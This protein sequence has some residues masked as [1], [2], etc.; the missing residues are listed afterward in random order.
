[1]Q[2]KILLNACLCLC[3]AFSSFAQSLPTQPVEVDKWLKTWLLWGPF[4]LKQ[5]DDPSKLLQHLEG[6]D[7][8]VL[9][10]LGGE[11]NL[12][13]KP[14]NTVTVG[15]K[16]YKW[17]L[18][19]T[20]DSTIDLQKTI[21]QASPVFAYAYTEV[22]ADA[23]QMHFLSFGTN[24]GGTLWFNGIKVWDYTPDRGLKAD[25]D[26]VPVLLKKGVNKI[27]LKVEQRG[28]RWEFC[29]R[30]RAFSLD[31]LSKSDLFRINSNET[32]E[33][34]L[35]S[36]YST[37][38]LKALVEDV[39]V[40]IKNSD[41]KTIFTNRFTSGFAQPID[42]GTTDYRFYTAHFKV[43]LKTGESINTSQNFY[44]GKRTEHE[45]FSKG[46]TAYRIALTNDASESEKWAANEL[47]RWLKEASG[48]L[49]P[50]ENL[51]KPF[52]G[53]QIILGYSILARDR[54]G[55]PAPAD[56]D[57]GYHYMNAG[58]D[59]LIF[60][61]KKRGTMYGV[62]AF[63]ENELGCRWY[64]PGYSVIPKK[65]EFKFSRLEHHE[66]PGV[67]V[68]NDFY[69][70][71]FDPIWATRNKM[72]GSMATPVQP[73]G[74]ESY[75]S[76]HTF[77]PL[78]SPA[79]FYDKHPEYFSL[80]NGKR[81]HERAQL[82]LSNPDVLKIITE[83]IKKQMRD[84][85]EY[86]IYDVS[87]NDWYNPCQCDKCQ[88]I[89]KKEGAESGIVIWFVNQVADAIA[90]EFPQKFIGTL[91]YQYTRKPPLHIR[92]K[93]NVVVRFCSIEC[94]FAH[95]FK[96]CPENQ[97]FL[98]ELNDWASRAPHLY[99]WDYVV[100]FNHYVMPFPNFNVLQSNIK[101]FRDNNAIGIMEQA[102]YQ[103]RGGEFAELR[104]Y[105]ISK[106]LWNP[107][108]DVP[109]VLSDFMHGYYGRSGKF[110]RQYFDLLQNQ[111][112]SDTHIH[113][114]LEPTDKIFTDEFVRKAFTLFEEAK[115]V[116]DNDEILHHVEMA[117]L[118]ILYLKCKRTP[119]LAKYDGTYD[120]FSKIAAR[121]KITH[122]AESG[123]LEA[124][125]SWMK[126][127]R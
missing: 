12:Q 126:S 44:A 51:G 57:E 1:M 18:H 93:D 119:A 15:K 94:C 78:L 76:V 103:S 56:S 42:L 13:V 55:R 30:L 95:D 16:T 3:L 28:N 10:K 63:L 66:K 70:E 52:R 41:D 65:T 37:N 87:Q 68:R 36:S 90:T 110:V 2:R 89:V 81:I 111:V 4:Q 88:S 79:E 31:A 75:W 92:P 69:F 17:T 118:P 117:S 125:H 50:I 33:S 19:T 20:P 72:N 73:G 97:G 5:P 116:A 127:V 77:Y 100:N 45:L 61:G 122:L 123:G 26:V 121:E 54:S 114:G 106:L 21:T 64:T 104:A 101:T 25:S 38:V 74:I 115:K 108:A 35:G 102:A 47:Q 8:N 84:N 27:L 43:R 82:C 58:S 49:F 39:D 22:T 124:F 80:I 99:I 9:A 62:L 32:G 85:P 29:M 23:D 60:G 71:A 67:R 83:R 112:T 24:D 48:V 40:A 96:S 14:G 113:L 6:Y 86:L 46:K 91:A 120:M 59:I 34:L 98:R 105:L 7:A 107:E 53:P 109:A 11:A